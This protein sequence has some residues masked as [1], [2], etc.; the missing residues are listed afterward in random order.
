MRVDGFASVSAPF[1]GGEMVTRPLTFAGSHLTINFASSA[2]GGLRVEIQDVSGAPI[3]GYAL[4]D[5]PE[6][7][8]DQIERV[9]S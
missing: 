8:G 9:V 4:D 7:I 2:A 5:C 3:S 1:A 6:I